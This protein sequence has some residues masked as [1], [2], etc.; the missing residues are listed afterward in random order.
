MVL[1]C[2]SRNSGEKN[3]D[4]VGRLLELWNVYALTHGE[5][6]AAASAAAQQRIV[7]VR[8]VMVVG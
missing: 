5:Q 7:R 8:F 3:A 2:R 4:G 6:E 1:V